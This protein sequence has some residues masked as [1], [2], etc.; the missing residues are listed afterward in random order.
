MHGPPPPKPHGRP[1]VIQLPGRISAS[2]RKEMDAGTFSYTPTQLP[3]IPSPHLGP[4]PPG[5]SSTQSVTIEQPGLGHVPASSLRPKLNAYA[6]TSSATFPQSSNPWQP[7]A[8]RF[9]F[10]DGTG[11]SYGSANIQQSVHIYQ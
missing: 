9:Q 7:P 2:M 8:K 3:Q 11:D 1:T 5:L 10:P 6:H 4:L